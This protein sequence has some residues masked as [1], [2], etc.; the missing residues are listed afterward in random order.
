MAYLRTYHL[1]EH[2]LNIEP[3]QTSITFGGTGQHRVQV[4]TIG[5]VVT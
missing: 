3:N 2:L 5:T 4:T 1:P